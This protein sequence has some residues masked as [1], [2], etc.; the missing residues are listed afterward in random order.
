MWK[1]R[2]FH[3]KGKLMLPEYTYEGEFK[4]GLFDGRGILKLGNL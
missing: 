4:N 1:Y 3:G 2:K